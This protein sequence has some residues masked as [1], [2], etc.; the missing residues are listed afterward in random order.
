VG[1][2]VGPTGCNASTKA[3][4]RASS[5]FQL[6]AALSRNWSYL[7]FSDGSE[8]VLSQQAATGTFS[9][10]FKNGWS[11]AL[12]GGAVFA[13]RIHN[14][15]HDLAFGP[16]FLVSA[17]VAWKWLEQRGPVPFIM[18]S[19]T[20]T[21]ARSRIEDSSG[22]VWGT[23]FRLGF[24]FGYTLFDVLSLY[25][26]PRVF[27]GPVFIDDATTLRGRDRF[28]FQVGLGAAFL[29]PAGLTL[30][31]D[32]SPGAEQSLSGGLAFSF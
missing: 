30:F 19:L 8:P 3:E 2:P 17:R 26:S 16:G 12:S 6:A 24:T 4:E 29:L 25:I 15:G 7:H 31:F 18:T 22:H 32:G 28:F 14:S 21:F 9:Y 11:I 1:A 23:D 10:F 13:G 20:A 5:G 27:G